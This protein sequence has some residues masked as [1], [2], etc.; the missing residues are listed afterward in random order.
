MARL[1]VSRFS[2]SIFGL[3]LA[4][5]LPFTLAL[6]VPLGASPAGLASALALSALLVWG[7]RGRV[8][9]AFDDEPITAA[10]RWLVE[11]PYYVHWCAVVAALPLF[12]LASPLSLFTPWRIG[13]L[14]LAAYLVAFV[15]ALW[16]VVA[17]PRMLR[18]RERELR[19]A[20]LPPA[21]DGYRVL[22]VSDVH[23]GSLFP[24]ERLAAWLGRAAALSPDLVALTGDYVTSGTRFH[25][26]AAETLASLR[27]KDG[28]VAV[29]GNHDDYGGGEPLRSSLRARGVELLDNAHRVYAR[30][31]ARLVVVGV[32]DVYSRR[33]DVERAFSG[34]PAQSFVVALAHEPG[35]FPRIAQRGA[36][37]VL[38]GHTHW[39]QLGVPWIAEHLNLGR[40]FYRYASGL[41]RHGRSLLH[42]S[43]GLGTTFVPARLGV[44]PEMTLLVLRAAAGDEA[45]QFST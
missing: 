15:A 44:A 9:L 31:E 1:S 36:A 19:V 2:V 32:D 25:E 20:G 35:L 10:R 27:G 16:G 11:V 29:A 21:F 40:F 6:L 12:V 5:H 30:G 41:A 23:L 33:V 43:P 39:G 4:A 3:T 18:L 24:P 28:I 8:R 14:A 38:S 17:R 13:E 26:A 45:D 42:V 34:V 37:L 22:H 7:L